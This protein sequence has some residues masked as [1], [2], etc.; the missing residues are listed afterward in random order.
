MTTYLDATPEAGK[1]FYQ[2]FHQKGRIIMLNLLR[3]KATADYS[4]LQDLKPENEVSG[5]EAYTTYLKCIAPL[6]E[7]S[8]SKILF[9]GESNSFLIGPEN[10]SWD[11]VLLVRHAS[12]AAFLEFA[13]SSEYL[14]YAGHRAAA[15]AD[16][17]LL[18]IIADPAAGSES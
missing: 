13:R 18:P 17:R 6:L 1:A 12:V 4:E 14:R 5:K 7:K 9:S 2:K 3:F 10:E 8:G 15:L 11:M 16:S